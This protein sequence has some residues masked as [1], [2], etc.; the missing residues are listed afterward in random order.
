[1]S[2]YVCVSRIHQKNSASTE[3]SKK[4]KKKKKGG[5]YIYSNRFTD[6]LHAKGTRAH[7]QSLYLNTTTGVVGCKIPR[8]ANSPMF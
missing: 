4:E 2:K 1:M 5:E 8:K 6:G 3:S 7:T